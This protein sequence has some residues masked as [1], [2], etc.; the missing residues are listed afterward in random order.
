[1]PII[2]LSENAS[3]D[4]LAEVFNRKSF[5]FQEYFFEDWQRIRWILNDQSKPNEH[6]FIVKDDGINFDELFPGDVQMN[7]RDRWR[8][9]DK[10][11]HSV[12]A[13][14]QIYDIGSSE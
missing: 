7:Q 4:A 11:F 13:Y 1:M 3:I 12:D 2:H 6:A 10:A 9:N 14:T 8:L 5:L